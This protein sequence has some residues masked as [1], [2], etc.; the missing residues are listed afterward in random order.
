M[1]QI[2]M[3]LAIT[4]FAYTSTE[5]QVCKTKS[6]A[7][8]TSTVRIQ[9]QKS[10]AQACRL[11]PYEVCSI[12]ADRRSVSCYKTMDPDAIQPLNDEVTYYGS[13]GKI[14]GQV[15]HPNI[16]TIVIKGSSKGD[17]CKRDEANNRTICYHE[18]GLLTRDEDGFY[19]YPTETPE[20]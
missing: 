7:R 15:E 9:K 2:L 12:N 3:A 18:G 16:K 4:A 19:H 20:R 14:P 11:L 13:E 10:T 1:K 5:A 17:Y 6:L 8:H